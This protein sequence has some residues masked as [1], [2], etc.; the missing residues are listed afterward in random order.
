MKIHP[1]YLMFNNFINTYIDQGFERIDRLD[2]IIIEM[3]K[4]L[5]RNKQ[6]FYVGDIIR[7]CPKVS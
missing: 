5:N 1:D 3:E 7:G 4:K 6:F 2:P